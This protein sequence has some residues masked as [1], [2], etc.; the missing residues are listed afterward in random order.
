METDFVEPIQRLRTLAANRAKS[1]LDELAEACRQ[2]LKDDL[3]L[4]KKGQEELEELIATNNRWLALHASR[5]EA[6]LPKILPSMVTY[7]QKCNMARNQLG[8]VLR[9]AA[10]I[11]PYDLCGSR[12]GGQRDPK[13]FSSVVGGI[14]QRLGMAR[15][16]IGSVNR[17]FLLI[18]AELIALEKRGFGEQPPEPTTFA[19][20]PAKVE[21]LVVLTNNDTE[22]DR[23]ATRRRKNP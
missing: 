11:S 12:L 16:L 5:F 9:D 1:E 4:G 13:A 3:Q 23:S 20:F 8:A 15:S 21:S 10:Q 7:E 6:L 19:E 14:K 18:E 22:L 17:A 2:T